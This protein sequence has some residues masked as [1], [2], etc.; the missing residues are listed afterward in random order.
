[1]KKTLLTIAIALGL[2]F[3]AFAQNDGGGLF[4]YGAVSDESCYGS[5]YSEDFNL[6]RDPILPDLPLQHGSDQSQSAPLGGGV[7]LLI[8]LGT[9]YAIRRAE[10]RRE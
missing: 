3:T 7:L 4:R 2:S 10:D 1:M 5:A 9:A 6:N 8:G